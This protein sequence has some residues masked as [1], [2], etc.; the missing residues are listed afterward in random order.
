MV[1]GLED[2]PRF[3]NEPFDAREA[4]FEDGVH[5]TAWA[6][7][8]ILE[9]LLAEGAPCEAGLRMTRLNSD[10][11]DAYLQSITA[12]MEG[13]PRTHPS[14]YATLQGWLAPD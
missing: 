14:E 12:A 8:Q 1:F 4:F 6:S 10:N 7:D 5:Y 9:C 3:I 11:I 2:N 13:Y